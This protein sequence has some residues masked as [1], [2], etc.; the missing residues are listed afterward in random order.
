M[1][2][3]RILELLGQ[4]LD[5]G[6]VLQQLA[7]KR[8]YL[9]TQPLEVARLTLVDGE[10]A[11]HGVGAQLE[12]THILEPLTVLNLTGRDGLGLHLELLR[13]QGELVVPPDELRAQRVRVRV[14]VRVRA[15]V[16]IGLG[17]G[18]G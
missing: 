6:P 8:V 7:L 3:V 4:G 17:L 11:P 16:K 12:H 9:G 13:Q 10:V 15:R 18:L 5:L 2:V 14:R 1:R